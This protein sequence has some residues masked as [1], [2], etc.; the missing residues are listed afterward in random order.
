M[1]KQVFLAPATG[2][3]QKWTNMEMATPLIERRFRLARRRPVWLRLEGL[4]AIGF[5]WS[6]IWAGAASFTTSLDR[7]TITLGET[8]T[9]SLTFQGTDSQGAPSLPAIPNL[10]IAYVGPSS[11]IS[12]VNGQMNSTVT[13]NFTVTPRQAGEFTIPALVAQVGQERLTTSPLTL[14]VLKPEAAP[15]DAAALAQQLA[16][17]RLQV[18]KKEF[19]VGEVFTIE[20]QLYVNVRQGVQNI[21]GF[22]VTAM[23]ADGFTVG[24]SV[25]GQQRQAQLGNVQWT[26]VPFAYPLSATRA[27]SLTLGPITVSVAVDLPSARR[28]QRGWPFDDFGFF[29][30]PVDRRQLTLATEAVPVHSM[31][32]PADNVPPNFNGAVGNFT[33]S[34]SAGPTNVAVGDPITIKVR[35]AGRGGLDALTLPGQTTWREFKAYPATMKPPEYADPLGIQGSKIFEQVVVPQNAEIKELPAFSFSFF[36]PDQKQYRTLTQPAVN[37]VV[38]PGGSV[39]APTIA[40]LKSGGQDT[41][42]PAQDIVPIKQRLGAVAHI[43]PPLVQQPSFL[44]LQTLPVFAWILAFAWRKRTEMLA[45]NPRLRRHRRL[46]QIIRDGLAE[47][48]QQAAE[49]KSEEFFAT[50][51]RLL[52]EQLGERLDLPASAITEAVIEEHLRPRS[53]PETTLAALHELFQTCNLARYAP[54]QSSQELAALIP[55]LER[56][57]HEIQTLKT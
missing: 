7:D 9:L 29:G 5:L 35:I 15:T 27:G 23:P 13:H 47:L 33:M 44:A 20:L 6:A 25:Q 37:L 30:S 40:A 57:L 21:A 48:R 38:R 42:P 34:V 17:V 56:T 51:F 52:Q 10:P 3:R 4:L 50:L 54:V 36:D 45:N 8:A 16:F 14:K 1:A 24:K 49:N 32:L 26:V 43:Q 18:P 2:R 46:I 55:K 19:Y 22:N 12:I 31:L 28:Q 11:Q 53:V 41:P 39:V